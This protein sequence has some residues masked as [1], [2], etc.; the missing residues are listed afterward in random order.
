MVFFAEYSR[1]LCSMGSKGNSSFP[2]FE[3]R[4]IINSEQRFGFR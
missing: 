2:L 4:H 3:H 1:S